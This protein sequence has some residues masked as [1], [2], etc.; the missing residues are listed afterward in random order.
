MAGALACRGLKLGRLQ[1]PQQ[2]SDSDAGRLLDVPLGKQCSN[3]FAKFAERLEAA[4]T[5]LSGPNFDLARHKRRI[6]TPWALAI[7]QVLAVGS[8]D[9]ESASLHARIAEDRT[10]L[11]TDS[12][13]GS[14]GDAEDVT[15]RVILIRLKVSVTSSIMA[16]PERHRLA[17]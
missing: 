11:R 9:C 1:P 12:N 4:P 3:S 17:P 2:S 15:G 13:M 6:A 5:N 7:E 16:C 8:P 14:P 10:A